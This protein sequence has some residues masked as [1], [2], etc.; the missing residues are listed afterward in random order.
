MEADSLQ[1][2]KDLMAAPSPSGFEQPAQKVVRERMQQ[3]ADEVRTD[4]HGNVIGVKNPDAAFRVMLAGHCDEI[5]LMITHVDEQGFCYFASIGGYDP[6]VLL[7]QRV[8]VHGP[9]G[10]VPGVIGRK[11][12]HL[13]DDE[14][15]KKPVKVE[16]LWIDIGARKRKDALSVVQVG[17]HVT[18]IAPFLQLRHGLAVS[19]GFDDKVGAFAVAEALRLV[20]HKKLDIG[21]YAV[22]TVQEEIGLRGAT[23][24][25]FGI[26]PKVGI[27]VDVGFASDCP[28]IDKKKVGEV[29]L[30]KGPILHRGANINPVLEDLIERTA[31]KKRIPFQMQAEPRATGTD[32]NVIQVNRAGVATA[33][34]SVPNR[35]M[36]TPVEMISL[37]DLENTAKLIAAVLEEIK[38]DSDFTP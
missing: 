4:V 12:I 11:P 16:D 15:R 2:L 33:L 17:S 26:D 35:Y 25:A 30:G 6:P 14:D 3:F 34:V 10:P 7:G 29:M 38:P 24:S 5:G 18:L 9:K 22:S 27:A 1:F 13:M 20:S 21:V 23:T 37:A 31:R 19:R 36:H 28:G 32:A 8:T